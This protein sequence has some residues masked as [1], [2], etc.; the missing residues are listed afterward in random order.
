MLEGKLIKLGFSDNEAKIY[1]S[2]LE[3]GF[4]TSGPLI[5]ETGLHRNIVYETLDK[6]IS[7]NLVSTTIKRGKKHFRPLS[8]EKIL[9][10]EKSRF[11]LAKTVVPELNKLKIKEKQEIT[12]YEGKEGFQNAH[13]D[14]VNQMPKN[15]IIYAMI[16]GGRRWTENMDRMVKKYDQIREKNDIG[17]KLLALETQKKEL[18]IQKNRPL[19]EIRFLSEIFNNPASIAI[20]NNVSLIMVFGQPVFVIM[21]KNDQVAQSFKQY[22]A[23][24]WKQAKLI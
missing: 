19:L 11:D 17:K 21:I 1:L 3:I 13:L 16:A 8:P 2:L 7:R 4:C 10:E 14:S 12:I 24:L 22:F 15:S 18:E 9:L 23:L 6:L 5:K 20:Y